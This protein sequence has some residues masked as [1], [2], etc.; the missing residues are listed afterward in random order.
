M[1]PNQKQQIVD[2]IIATEAQLEFSTA[3]HPLNEKEQREKFLSGEVD[4]PSFTYKE[5]SVMVSPTNHDTIFPEFEVQTEMDSLYRDRMGLSKGLTLLLELVGSD[6]EFSAFSEILYPVTDVGEPPSL[7]KDTETPSIPAEKIAETFRG[8]LASLNLED[9]TVE[10]VD[11]CSSRLFV[12]QWAKKV[13]VRSN[14]SVTKKELSDLTRHEIGVHVLR[15]AQGSKQSEPLLSVGTLLGRIIEEGVACYIENPAGHPRI[16][17]RHLAVQTALGHSFRETWQA[18][19]ENGCTP[20]E[21]WTHTLRVKRGLADGA[22]HGAFTRDAL[23][24]Q[25]YEEI[26]RYVE[27]RGDL[28]PL[29]SAPIHPEEIDMLKGEAN[30][31]I[32]DLIP[33]LHGNA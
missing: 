6:R 5:N 12:N 7:Q 8:A 19:Q 33:T 14:V 28:T 24:A 2:A 22:S 20:E 3:L 17:E 29:L 26:R 25:G 15:Y 13:V 11:A 18:L 10:I 4:E 30:L 16:Y 23:Y 21:A 32:F 9:W 1:L 27:K 31:H